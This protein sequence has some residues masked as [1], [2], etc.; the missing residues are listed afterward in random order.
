MKKHRTRSDRGIYGKRRRRRLRRLMRKL[1]GW[2][3]AMVMVA[4]VCVVLVAINRM[5]NMRQK[6]VVASTPVATLVVMPTDTPRPTDAMTVEP[7]LTA[8]P[9]MAPTPTPTVEPTATPSPTPEPTPSPTP[10]DIVDEKRAA[11]RPG[12]KENLLPVFKRADTDEKM[13]AI[14]VD[15]CYQANNLK[16]IIELAMEYDGKLTIFPIGDAAKGGGRRRC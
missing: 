13:I 16:K 4:L 5:G 1:F 2:A 10:Y 11:L 6:P 7:T 8:E 9:T 12:T 3:A 15:D 14:T